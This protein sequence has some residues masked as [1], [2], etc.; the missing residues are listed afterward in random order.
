MEILGLGLGEW[1]FVLVI[2]FVVMGPKDMVALSRRIAAASRKIRQSD[3]WR[4]IRETERELRQVPQEL[5]KETQLNEFGEERRSILAD[6]AR[7]N[8]ATSWEAGAGANIRPFQMD[9][10]QNQTNEPVGE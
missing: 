8:P 2:L 4:S 1:A 9:Q 7:I 10:E 3:L 6:V 5:M